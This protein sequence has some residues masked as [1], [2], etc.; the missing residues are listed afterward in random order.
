MKGIFVAAMTALIVLAGALSPPPAP[1]A[2]A[3]LDTAIEQ[4]KLEN[5]EEAIAILT[6]VRKQDPKSTAAAFFLGLSHKQAMDFVA[7]ADNLRDAVTGSPPIKEALV[8]L[9]EV[10][11][12]LP[13]DKHLV[14]AKRWLAVAEREKIDPAKIAFLSGLV[15]QRE[16]RF[17]EAIVDFE[18]AKEL[19]PSSSQSADVQIGLCYVSDKKLQL[20]A[21]RFRLAVVH[22]PSSDL[23]G[24]A[25]RYQDAVE[26][27]IEIEKPFHYSV[28]FF[29]QYDSNL[30]LKPNEASLATGI[31]D[32]S[33][34]T[35]TASARV[36][37]APILENNWLF[38]ASYVFSSDWHDNHSTT[39]DV[40]N[41]TITMAP[42]YNFGDYALNLSTTYSYA[43]L[44]NPRYDS[45]LGYLNI[46]PLYRR[47]LNQEQI[48]EAFAGYTK[49]EYFQPPL[50]A[51]E[52]RN[53]EGLLA[54]LSWIWLYRQDGFLN[55]KYAYSNENAIGVNWQNSGHRISANIAYPLG[56]YL[57]GLKLQAS[58]QAF[59]QNYDNDHT[60]FLV[61]REDRNYMGA[62]GLNWEVREKTNLVVQYMKTRA[63][64]NVGIYDY[65]RDQVTAGIEYTF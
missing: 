34:A 1:A 3:S 57:K 28:S 56:D 21:E 40:I 53:S 65:D 37:Y 62:V 17:V 63:E 36:D 5:Y 14:E 8:E 50:T 29:G 48:I 59:W 46:G 44:K 27:R 32:E 47:L 25:R 39:H 7:A 52:N 11:Y 9:I 2:G 38:N 41:N 10:L 42:G 54:S 51:E 12:R 45:Y 33:S 20:A 19:D 49:S 22:D 58:A 35:W 4:Y 23:G 60:V 6:R 61:K 15:K 64:S 26:R 16:K 13:D 24:F 55:L 18:R 43:L 31:T 30:V